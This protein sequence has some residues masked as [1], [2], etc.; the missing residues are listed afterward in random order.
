[1]FLTHF[2]AGKKPQPSQIRVW[3]SLSGLDSERTGIQL[4]AKTASLASLGGRPFQFLNARVKELASENPN[5]K[6]ISV[7]DKLLSATSWSASSLRMSFAAT[8]LQGCLTREL[9]QEKS[10]P[11]PSTGLSLNTGA[12]PFG[13]RLDIFQEAATQLTVVLAKVPS[14]GN[15]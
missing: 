3:L 12:T 10:C 13:G 7:N 14:I 6:D 5:M 2:G 9:K 8:W 4:P 15:Y 11:Q 1:M